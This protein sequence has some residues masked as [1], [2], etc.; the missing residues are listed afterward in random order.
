M[1]KFIG[2]DIGATKIAGGILDENANII[3]TSLLPTLAQEDSDTV[4]KQVFKSIDDLNFN[5]ELLEG[6]GVCAPGPLHQGVII[7]PPNIPC[8]RNL[9][10]ANIIAERYKV[11]VV[12][13]NDANAA[14]YAEMIFGAAKGYK[15]FVYITI[16]TGIGTGIVI[17]GEIYR[18]KNSLAGEGGHLTTNYKEKIDCSCGVPGCIESV[19]SGTGIA[20]RAQEKLKA[21]PNI[22]TLIKEFVHDDLSKITTHEINRAIK[23]N[24][25][26][27]KELIEEAA[28]QIGIWLGG[29]VS[30]LDPEIIVIGGGVSQIGDILFNKI[31][32]TMPK[33]TINAFA[34]QT[35]IVPAALQ[36]NVGIYGAASLLF[37]SPLR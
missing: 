35:P 9:P 4:L 7:N 37:N 25:N 26:F 14:G 12:L 32:E 27:A 2:L 20:K 17:N 28:Y 23:A 8:W 1:S 15:N 30:L 22:T 24:D 3:E 31:K 10:L 36:K 19:A 34:N 6:I 21:N 11:P 13:E 33:F 5:H 29:V 18:G 16:S